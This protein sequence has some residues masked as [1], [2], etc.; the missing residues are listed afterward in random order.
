MSTEKTTP[1][2]PSLVQGDRKFNVDKSG[3]SG[4]PFVKEIEV[5]S[6]QIDDSLDADCDPYNRTGQFLIQGLK[7]DRSDA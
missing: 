5:S 1:R 4:L 3:Q 7:K 2:S 6:L